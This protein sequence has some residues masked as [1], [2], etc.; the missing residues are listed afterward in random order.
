MR[1]HLAALAAATILVVAGCP[2]KLDRPPQGKQ[3][4]VRRFDV[5]PD[6]T[7]TEAQIELGKEL[8]EMSAARRVDAMRLALVKPEET[9]CKDDSDCAILP[10]HCCSC[11]ER[12]R[13]V[14]VGRAYVPKVI[15]RRGWVC[16]DYACPQVVSDDPSCKATRSLCQQ[17]R[18]VL[19]I[20]AGAGGPAGIGVE[21]I[22]DEAPPGDPAPPADPP[23]PGTP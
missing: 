3:V 17:G 23:A 1:A 7:R 11:S 14:A 12:G 15:Q 21:E 6:T 9:R 20:P 16:E 4:E 18:C 10:N 2:K 8:K 19:D 5:N 22:P 13:L